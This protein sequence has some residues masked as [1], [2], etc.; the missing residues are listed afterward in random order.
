MTI[1]DWQEIRRAADLLRAGGLVAIPTETVY[2]LAADATNDKAVAR[3]FA[4]KG[5]P[6]FNPLI[7]HVSGTGMAQRFVD[8]PPLAERLAAEFWPGPLTLVL[9]RRADCAVSLLASAGLDTLGVRAPN[10]AIA[11]AVIKTADIP[12]AAP[13]AN[14]SGAVSPTRAEH[15]REGI[16]DKIDM[17]LD[18]GPCPVGV[19]STIVRIDGE[20]AVLLRPGG[21]AREAIERVI[22]HALERPNETKVEAPGMLASHY[23]P[24]APLRLNVKAPAANEVFLAFGPA[25][26]DHPYTLSLSETG[27]LTEAAANL[28]VRLREAD[29]LCAA[30]SLSAI[31][32]APMPETG[33]GEAINDRLRRAAA[34]RP[35]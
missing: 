16:G 22:G 9:K 26:A 33:L 10:H 27:D 5:R 20:R 25:P 18:G 14:P 32:A 3:I 15:V 13:S 24:A 11:Q 8:M 7:V 6:Q 2:G 29:A 30:S 31:A 35:A 4:A 1:L 28:F 17:V 21:V 34:P 23:A 19:E 12:L